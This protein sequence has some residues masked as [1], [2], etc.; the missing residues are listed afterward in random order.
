M[1]KENHIARLYTPHS[2]TANPS[3]QSALEPVSDPWS[4]RTLH[5]TPPGHEARGYARSRRCRGPSLRRHGKCTGSCLPLC[6]PLHADFGYPLDFV[7]SVL[8]L[9]L[10]S[11]QPSQEIGH[12]HL[13]RC[14][15][16]RALGKW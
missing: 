8:Y 3:I 5:G 7:M 9:F 6:F 1:A 12:G 15:A 11:G 10:M 4:A 13:L 16:V 14:F 2:A